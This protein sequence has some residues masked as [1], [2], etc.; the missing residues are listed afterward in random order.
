[1]TVTGAIGSSGVEGHVEAA[2]ADSEED[3]EH[4]PAEAGAQGHDGV[5][6]AGDGDV[7]DEVAEGVADGEDG[8]AEEGVADVEDDADGLEEA[9]D[10]GGYAGDPGDGDD[11]AQEGEDGA[12]W[13]WG[14]RGMVVTGGDDEAGKAQEREEEREERRD[15][16]VVGVHVWV[17]GCPPDEDDEKW[18]CEELQRN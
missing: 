2:E 16:E 1:M 9:D 18:P 7:G 5:A 8:Q 10:F 15:Q 17:C 3:V 14:L 4:G 6:E 11:K 13:A 12:P